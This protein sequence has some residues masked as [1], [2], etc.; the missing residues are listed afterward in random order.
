MALQQ[1]YKILK[2]RWIVRAA[3]AAS[4]KADNPVL[5]KNEPGLE[6]DTKLWK[7]GDGTTAWNSI[8]YYNAT[9]YVSSTIP[10]SSTVS[11]TTTTGDTIS[12]EVGKWLF[13]TENGRMYY[14]SSVNAG[15]ALWEEAVTDISLAAQAVQGLQGL[16]G[17]QGA[18]GPGIV[19]RESR[20]A[21][22]SIGDAY[23]GT[24]DGLTYINIAVGVVSG[25]LVFSSNQVSTIQGITGSQGAQ[26]AAGSNGS[27]GAQG[28]QGY[29]GVKGAD[30]ANGAAGS[31][32]L[33]GLQ[34]YQGTRGTN[35]TNGT[36]GSQGAQ[37]I[38]G[39]AGPTGSTGSTGLTGPQGY[40]G[41][42][43]NTG[44][45]G[46][47]GPQGYQGIQGKAGSTGS[48]GATGSTGSTGPQGYQGATGTQGSTGSTG[49]TGSTGSQGYQGYRGYTGYGV[50]GAQ[51]I[52][53][54]KGDSGSSGS[55][56]SQGY[57]GYQGPQGTGASLTIADV[58]TAAITG[59][60]S[61]SALYHGSSAT[62]FTSLYSSSFYQTSDERKKDFA[63][64]V[65]ANYAA[66]DSIPKKYFTW[67]GDP[68]SIMQIGTSAQKLKESY[69]ELV[70]YDKSSDAYYVDYAKLSIIALAAVADLNRR[71][72]EVEKHIS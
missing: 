4:W 16:R 17:L 58:A 47:T 29:Q 60:S 6:I 14:L 49:G 32:G 30:G 34:G 23:I 52:Q 2:A 64:D 45:T 18:Y 71:L 68:D 15:V 46:S 55:S 5:L 26:G 63:G 10:T 27:N 53:G 42:Q 37:G 56:G 62:P 24:I 8:S 1:Y 25:D 38:T 67:K 69:P 33:Q 12:Y 31:Q 65:T 11:Y 7:I 3:T 20:E 51:G 36:N 28:L 19:W 50:D 22:Q 57:Q 39:S 72:E 9:D 59:F 41:W 40:Q 70:S 21:C 54:L 48:T 66:I 44:S 13:C 61:G 43:G 35:G